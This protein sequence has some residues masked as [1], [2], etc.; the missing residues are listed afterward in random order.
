MAISSIALLLLAAT[1]AIKN[2]VRIL[3]RIMIP[4]HVMDCDKCYPDCPV[5]G[6]CSPYLV[7][8]SWTKC[9]YYKS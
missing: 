5:L 8:E 9:C 3:G 4:N 6:T 2:S 7:K 1:G